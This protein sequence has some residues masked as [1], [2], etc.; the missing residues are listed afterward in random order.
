[1]V[2]QYEQLKNKQNEL[3]RKALEGSAFVGAFDVPAIGS[4]TEYSAT[5]VAGEVAGSGNAVNIATAGN[6]VVRIDGGAPVTVALAAADAPS[7]V[8][9]KVNTAIG[10]AGTAS[11]A[12]S[13]FKIVSADTGSDSSVQV[14]SGTG[15]VLANLFLVAGQ[16]G[17]GLDA[18]VNLKPLPAGWDDLGW[19]STDGAQYSRDVASSDVSSWGS[20][21]P[22]RS[23]ITSDTSTL[24][25]TAQET[26]L[27][28][29][30][31]A[32]GADLAAVT[33]DAQTGEVSIEK[34][35]RPAG[36]HYRALSV[37]VDLGDAGE[38]YVARFFPRAKVTNYQEQSFGGG[39]DP[40]S[41][42][43][44]LTG[45]EDSALGYSERWL[46][47]GAGW[48]ALLDDMGIPFEA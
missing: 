4:L 9:T 2:A 27:L 11:L 35:S 3:I 1:M 19:L 25:V 21:T 15:T 5:A 29:I 40:I 7:A 47:G 33:A 45:E 36:R 46:F 44:T 6:L 12:S 31:L 39:D 30:G 14:V 34:P 17:F 28:T 23:D 16:K 26:K 24:A 32:T 20:V 10:S 8:V 48:F 38:I 18:G 41:W 13:V 37:A 42:G 43:V 22:T